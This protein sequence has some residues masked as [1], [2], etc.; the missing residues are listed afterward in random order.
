MAHKQFEASASARKLLGDRFVTAFASVK[1][2]EYQNYLSE[3]GAW[4]RRFL[5][6]LA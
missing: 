3:V 1:E 4:E 2:I 6:P 5:L